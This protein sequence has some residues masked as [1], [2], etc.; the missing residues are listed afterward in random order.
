MLLLR[1]SY[2][3]T[4]PRIRVN[5]RIRSTLSIPVKTSFWYFRHFDNLCLRSDL[6]VY[7]KGP[8]DLQFYVC[9]TYFLKL[10]TPYNEDTQNGDRI[11]SWSL[12]EC[13]KCFLFNS[14]SRAKVWSEKKFTNSVPILSQI[15]VSRI[16]NFFS[17]F[18]D[19]RC[20]YIMS[21]G[22]PKIRKIDRVESLNKTT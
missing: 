8:L 6:K 11:K 15:K 13:S 16:L 9:G 7:L 20:A 17:E 21:K 4:F 18:L 1:H 5:G 19:I 14:D 3:L 10:K 22:P 12:S 2:S